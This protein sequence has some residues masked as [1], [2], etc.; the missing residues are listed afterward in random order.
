MQP[1]RVG[2]IILCGGL[3]RRM[4]HS[5]AW[6]P[7]GAETLLQRVVRLLGEAVTPL[8]VV[9]A[10]DQMLPGLPAG[11]DVARDEKEGR[12]PLQGLA[13]GLAALQGRADAAYVS[14]CDVP[15]LKPAFILRIIEL[16][17]EAAICVPKVGEYYHPLAA[18]YRLSVMNAAH[19]LLSANRLRPVFLYEI[20][21]TRVVAALELMDV[22][23]EF[24]TLRN[25]NDPRDYE[26]ALAKHAEGP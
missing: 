7:F 18:V 19:E 21:A 10:P 9:A 23:P 5:K 16:L 22:D 11:V 25:V 2:G 13:A 8:V 15:F 24:A 26:A 1:I 17:G 12:G 3:S 6:L 14:G 20:V 4:G